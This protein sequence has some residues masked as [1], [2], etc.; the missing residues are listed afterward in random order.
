MPRH[1]LVPRLLGDEV[2]HRA[3]QRVERGIVKPRAARQPVA[4]G[5]ARAQRA[6]VPHDIQVIGVRGVDHFAPDL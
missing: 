5:L 1:L 6:V 4:R 3:P 2:C